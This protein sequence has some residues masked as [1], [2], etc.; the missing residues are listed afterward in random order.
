MESNREDGVKLD[1]WF[2]EVIDYVDTNYR[3]MKPSTVEWTE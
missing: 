1:S 2:D 3:T